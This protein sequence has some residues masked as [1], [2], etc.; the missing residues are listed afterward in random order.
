M[1]LF[2]NI[3]IVYDFERQ[4]ENE[5]YQNKTAFSVNQTLCYLVICSFIKKGIR[6]QNNNFAFY[7]V[8]IIDLSSQ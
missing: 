3:D 6:P 2:K 8:I 7:Y 1:G 4:K 5:P